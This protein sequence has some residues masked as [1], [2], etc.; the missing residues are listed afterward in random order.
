MN[1]GPQFLDATL[2]VQVLDAVSQLWLQ[3]KLLIGLDFDGVLAPLVDD[4]ATARA[5]PGTL[6]LVTELADLPGVTVAVISGRARADLTAVLALPALS[7]I[8]RIGSHGAEFGPE[9]TTLDAGAH[10]RLTAIRARLGRVARKYPGTQLEHKPTAAVLHTRR[11]ASAE[12]AQTA[13]SAALAELSSIDGLHLI[14]GKDVLEAAVTEANKGAAV[15]RLR[16][17]LGPDCAVLYLGDD[18]TDERVFTS[19]LPGDL[20]IKVGAG[21]SAATLRLDSPAQVHQFLQHLAAK[22]RL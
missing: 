12:T 4:P 1:N 19:L 21:E 8:L 15:A 5:L 7:P 20:G 6:N 9:H 11:V 14:R 2:P 17:I 13:T 10:R 18:Q 3:P 16:R 22:P